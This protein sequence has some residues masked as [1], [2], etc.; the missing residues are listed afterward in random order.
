M[1]GVSSTERTAGRKPDKRTFDSRCNRPRN[2]QNLL[3]GILLHP[4][5]QTPVC[6]GRR[7]RRQA[8][9]RRLF[10]HKL[11]NQFR[12]R[13]PQLLRQC[14][15][16]GICINRHPNIQQPF[17]MLT[18]IR[19]ILHHNAGTTQPQE[20]STAPAIK[21][22]HT[23]SSHTHEDIDH[24]EESSILNLGFSICKFGALRARAGKKVV[25][26]TRGG[27]TY[28]LWRAAV[29]VAGVL[30]PCGE[31]RRGWRCTYTLW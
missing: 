29:V 15:K 19:H 6:I 7:L 12:H 11:H 9:P 2:P 13:H 21:K 4:L 28:T 30:T 1:A 3:H 27:C 16:T 20:R 25:Q 22:R 24:R 17:P 5:L 23:K 14:R 8:R 26:S 10:L 31:L 18:L